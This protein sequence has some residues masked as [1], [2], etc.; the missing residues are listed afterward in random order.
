[1]RRKD[2]NKT[3]IAHKNIG[4]VKQKLLSNTKGTCKYLR[5]FF[6]SNS[7]MMCF[8]LASASF[9]IKLGDLFK[10]SILKLGSRNYKYTKVNKK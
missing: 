5:F 7:F 3:T 6:K 2:S 8:H 10:K 1:M 4:Y 9:R